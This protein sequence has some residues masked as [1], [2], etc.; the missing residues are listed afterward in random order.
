MHW[1]P[2]TG[3]AGGTFELD[4]ERPN[5]APRSCNRESAACR[6]KAPDG[7]RAP[8]RNRSAPRWRRPGGA[9]PGTCSELSCSSPAARRFGRT[10]RI[11]DPLGFA[12]FA[13]RSGPSRIPGTAGRRKAFRLPLLTSAPRT[14]CRPRC[15][16]R[17]STSVRHHGDGQERRQQF[18]LEEQADRDLD[19][20]SRPHQPSGGVPPNAWCLNLNREPRSKRCAAMIRSDLGPWPIAALAD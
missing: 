4:G 15:A 5:P 20:I 8:S 11:D 9:R 13:R 14:A 17:E 7:T 12:L 2:A 18:L 6:R 16:P 19:A 10:R 3:H 1:R